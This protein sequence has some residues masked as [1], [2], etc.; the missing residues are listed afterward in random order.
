MR[1]RPW[2]ASSEC[3]QLP[4]LAEPGLWV[5]RPKKMVTLEPP[6]WKVSEWG[7]GQ[8]RPCAVFRK[9]Y[10]PLHSVTLFSY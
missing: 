7:W 4:V 6:S 2:L 8:G 9:K 10:L 3:Q 1:Q 5:S